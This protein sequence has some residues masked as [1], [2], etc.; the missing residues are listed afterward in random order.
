MLTCEREPSG[1]PKPYAY[2]CLAGIRYGEC[3]LPQ[4]LTR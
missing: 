4:M 3:G 2:R 1:A